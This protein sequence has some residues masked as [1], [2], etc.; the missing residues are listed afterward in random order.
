MYDDDYLARVT[1]CNSYL[2][3]TRDVINR[4][5]IVF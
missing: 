2:E 4:S 5:V 3:V 1:D